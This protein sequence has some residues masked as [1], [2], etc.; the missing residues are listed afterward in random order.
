M[1]FRKNKKTTKT[2]KKKTKKR[3]KKK[4][5]KTFTICFNLRLQYAVPSNVFHFFFHAHPFSQD[6]E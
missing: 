1:I 5:K 6:S 3:K 4:K 2:E